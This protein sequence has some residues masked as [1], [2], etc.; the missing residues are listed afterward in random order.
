VP[1]QS[2]AEFNRYQYNYPSYFRMMDN[3]NYRNIEHT[4]VN[5]DKVTMV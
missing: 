4:D 2:G 3:P 1:Q 5:G